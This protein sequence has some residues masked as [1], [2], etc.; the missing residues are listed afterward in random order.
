MM[1][2]RD[3]SIFRNPEKVWGGRSAHD[4]TSLRNP[5][6][7]TKHFRTHTHPELR[8]IA[9]K[10]QLRLECSDHCDKSICGLIFE[11]FHVSF[12]D[13]FYYVLTICYTDLSLGP[14]SA[15]GYARASNPSSMSMPSMSNALMM[16]AQRNLQSKSKVLQE[17]LIGHQ[18]KPD[19]S[20]ALLGACIS[21]LFHVCPVWWSQ[22]TDMMWGG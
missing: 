7:Q 8:W 11:G 14:L 12:Q 5:Q 21:L 4:P 22:L 1:F 10:S 9:R 2:R 13:K 18:V 16:I 19:E 20:L 17:E 6:E 15:P 3:F